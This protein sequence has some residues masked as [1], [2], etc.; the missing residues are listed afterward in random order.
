ML[1]G[2]RWGWTKNARGHL[3][4]EAKEETEYGPLSAQE[5]VRLARG[6]FTAGRGTSLELRDAELRLTQAR[7]TVISARL[8]VE[9]ARAALAYVVGV[10]PFK[11]G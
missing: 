10:D 1:T 11:E 2:T 4:I 9:V 3:N 6:L 7:L 8:D 5:A